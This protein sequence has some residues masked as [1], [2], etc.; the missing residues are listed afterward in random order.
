M[1]GLAGKVL[2]MRIA[3]R[4]SFIFW[5]ILFLTA[6]GYVISRL[7]TFKQIF[8]QHAG[9]ELTQAQA[10]DAYKD[11][12]GP[13][14]TRTQYIPKIVHQVF[15]NWH[16]PG[17]DT[18][19]ADWAENVRKCS[20]LSPDFEFKL[21]TEKASRD[22]IEKEYPWFLRTYD[23]YHHK[24]Q[25][26]DA[27]RYFLL[28]HY[29][30]LYMDLDNGCLANL[31]PLLYYPVFVVDGAR[32]ALS[33]NIL[34]AMPNHPF[35]THLTMSLMPYNYN[36]IFPYI[37]ISYASGQWFE[38]AVWESYHALL[39]KPSANPEIEHRLYRL[40]MDNRP[41]ADKWIFFTQERGGSW[42]NWDNVLFAEIGEHL[43][44]FFLILFGSLGLVSW[45]GLRCTRKY[46]SGYTRVKNSH[47]MSEI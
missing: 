13:N 10:L 41:T 2:K 1:L 32:G 39:P 12:S 46:R 9:L 14:R 37:T 28:L 23:G 47:A 22:F 3:I 35:W 38:T 19:P 44:L 8:F 43:F 20:K 27:V 18:L 34:G 40:L 24:V 16:D 4:I 36:Y 25:R 21:W 17:N 7:L 5:A 29:G 11:D 6:V 33:N 31:E 15:H 45:I 42:D 26:V 30:G